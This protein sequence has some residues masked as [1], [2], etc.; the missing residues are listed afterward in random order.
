MGGHWQE[1]SFNRSHGYPVN[2]SITIITSPLFR[3]RSMLKVAV[4]RGLGALHQYRRHAPSVRNQLGLDAT[5]LL[6]EV[7]S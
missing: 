2:N 3:P 5:C 1:I 4:R 6:Y 7:S